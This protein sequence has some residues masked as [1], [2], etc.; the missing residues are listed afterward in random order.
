MDRFDSPRADIALLFYLALV[1]AFM[2]LFAAAI[3][4]LTRPT[5]L[6]N[7]GYAAY[8]PPVQAFR[9]QEAA[10]MTSAEDMEGRALAV[11]E[12]ENAKQGID[13][14]MAFA[15]VGRTTVADRRPPS[16]D[17]KPTPRA[18]KKRRVAKAPRPQRV[19]GD[20]WQ[21]PWARPR[22]HAQAQ[23]QHR[24]ARPQGLFFFF[25]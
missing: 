9:F 4:W 1:I 24:G 8:K 25:Q 5:V 7:A 6:P 20:A 23:I 16:H 15:R 12:R 21:P 10:A 11:A 18:S 19:A 22:V 13:A 14:L 2:G 3:F 17:V